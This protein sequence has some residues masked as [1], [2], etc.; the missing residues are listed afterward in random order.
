MKITHNYVTVESD[1]DYVWFDCQHYDLPDNTMGGAGQHVV[2]RPICKGDY[3]GHE[4]VTDQMVNNARAAYEAL[5]ATTEAAKDTERAADQ[6]KRERFEAA[7]N[8]IP[9]AAKA[10]LAKLNADMRRHWAGINEGGEGYVP[11]Y[12]WDSKAGRTIL[13][14]YGVSINLSDLEV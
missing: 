3:R 6:I 5:Q 14:K 2:Y 9:E 7:I 12:G 13:A 10:E 1:S 8:A 11:Q 4:V